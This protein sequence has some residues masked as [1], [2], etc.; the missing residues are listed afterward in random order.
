MRKRAKQIIDLFPLVQYQK[1][2]KTNTEEIHSF[3][4]AHSHTQPLLTEISWYKRNTDWVIIVFP[5][6]IFVPFIWN[7]HQVP[8][9]ICKNLSFHEDDK[10]VFVVFTWVLQVGKYLL[11]TK[12]NVFRENQYFFYETY[13]HII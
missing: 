1:T 12:K 2:I 9:K 3:T 13:N 6:T 7:T 8:F 10:K 5:K 4:V 11:G